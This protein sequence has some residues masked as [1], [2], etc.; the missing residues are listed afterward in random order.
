MKETPMKT[1]ALVH[2]NNT[3]DEL[4]VVREEKE[5][6]DE[7]SFFTLAAPGSA[8]PIVDALNRSELEAHVESSSS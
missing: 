2:L 8:R 6:P 4:V 5:A 1:Y 3:N 7:W